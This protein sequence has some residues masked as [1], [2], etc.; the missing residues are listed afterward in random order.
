M[1]TYEELRET[2]LREV[3]ND[4]L[5]EIPQEFFEDLRSTIEQIDGK[6]R[7]VGSRQPHRSLLVEERRR[8]LDLA[9]LLIQARCRKIVL[10]A[11]CTSEPPQGKGPDA[12]LFEEVSRSVQAHMERFY[13]F[14]GEEWG[15]GKSAEEVSSGPPR[16]SGEARTEVQPAGKPARQRE[17][18][19]I[20]RDFPRFMGTD[21]KVYGPF[22]AEDVVV[23]PEEVSGILIER[24]AAKLIDPGSGQG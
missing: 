22:G 16:R 18:L 7:E 13:R 24:K 11:C 8:L 21:L 2:L 17:A 20:V 12:K 10:Q 1:L 9:K 6:I 23:L 15:K 14:L 5:L 4:S 3:S 19:A